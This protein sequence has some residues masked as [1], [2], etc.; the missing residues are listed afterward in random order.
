[1]KIY[2]RKRFFKHRGKPARI[3]MMGNSFITVINGGI[4]ATFNSMRELRRF[5]PSKEK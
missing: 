4:V 3:K 1:M 5:F 2:D